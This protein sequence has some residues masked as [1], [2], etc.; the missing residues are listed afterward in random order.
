MA[1]VTIHVRVREEQRRRLQATAAARGMTLSELLR[2]MLQGTP[3]ADQREPGPPR[4]TVP[5]RLR[6]S[7]LAQLKAASPPRDDHE[8][9][10]AFIGCGRSGRPDVSLHHDDYL[11]GLRE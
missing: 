8:A 9:L 3:E 1:M 7:V 11:A 10:R 2:D 5:A 6:E 4:P